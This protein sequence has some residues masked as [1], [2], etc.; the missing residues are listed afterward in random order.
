MATAAN[1]VEDVLR[2]YETHLGENLAE[3]TYKTPVM[4]I[5]LR[6]FGCAFC[7]QAL[8]DIARQREAIEGL[9]T[10]LC[11]VHMSAEDEQ[12]AAFFAKYNVANVHRVGD[13]DCALYEAFGLRRGGSYILMHPQ[14]VSKGIA[15]FFSGGHYIGLPAGDVQRMPG[16]FLVFRGVVM[17]SFIHELPSDRPDYRALAQ[18]SDDEAP[19]FT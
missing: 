19:L 7:R 9:K 16:V 1:S 4:V 5:F 10:A 6:H 12:A 8:A 15:A 17:R 11:F 2:S 14:V 3:L 18:C 13:P